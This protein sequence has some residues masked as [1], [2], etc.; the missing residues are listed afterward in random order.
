MFPSMYN[1]QM[2]KMDGCDIQLKLFIRNTWDWVFVSMPMR[3]RKS[4]DRA[5]ADGG[6]FRSPKFLI[7]NNKFY[8]QF[9]V[10]F[11]RGNFPKN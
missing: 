7:R 9:P 6:R 1:K 11:K 5:I 10:L 8:L 3:D 4:L 2:Y